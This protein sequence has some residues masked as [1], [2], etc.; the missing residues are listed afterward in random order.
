MREIGIRDGIEGT[1][2]RE[3]GGRGE[4]GGAHKNGGVLSELRLAPNGLGDN[5]LSGLPSTGCPE[6]FWPH[7]RSR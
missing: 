2:R 7:V 4:R 1:R 5:P 3:N 6:V